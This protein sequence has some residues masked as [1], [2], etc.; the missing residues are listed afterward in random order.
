MKREKRRKENSGE[1][2]SIRG[3]VLIWHTESLLQEQTF[4]AVEGCERVTTQMV[5]EDT[6]R[7]GRTIESMPTCKGDG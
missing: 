2:I 7:A 4:K 3:G 5:I 6:Q 1:Q